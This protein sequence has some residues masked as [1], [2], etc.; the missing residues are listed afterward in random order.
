M[1][2]M[3]TAGVFVGLML[4]G[5]V[6]FVL[7]FRWVWN[8]TMPAVF[9]VRAITFWQAIGILFLAMIL[10][11]GHRLITPDISDL[12]KRLAPPPLGLAPAG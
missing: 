11:G 10:T 7:V 9:G 6:V 2:P 8:W 3:A 4:L 5:F 12:P 1:E